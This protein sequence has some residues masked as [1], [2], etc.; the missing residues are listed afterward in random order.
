MQF[1]AGDRVIAKCTEYYGACQVVLFRKG[2][3]GTVIAAYGQSAHV[4]W[5]INRYMDGKWYA[6]PDQLEAAPKGSSVITSE[7]AAL[8]LKDDVKL[9]PT[10][11]LEVAHALA[12]IFQKNNPEFDAAEFYKIADLRS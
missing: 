10:D 1:K 5:D 11:K 9:F 7:H 8:L 4:R 3:K 12:K 2:D 6:S